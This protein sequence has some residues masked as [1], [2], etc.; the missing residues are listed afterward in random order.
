LSGAGFD[1]RPVLHPT[2]PEDKERIRICLH[3]FNG[4]SEIER[5]LNSLHDTWKKY[6]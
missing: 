2:V 6:S 1:V 3:V 5:L 4:E